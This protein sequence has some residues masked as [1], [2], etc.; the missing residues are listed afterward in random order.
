MGSRICHDLISPLGAIGNGV[1]LIALSGQEQTPEIALIAESVESANARIRFFR[2]AFGAAADEQTIGAQ[3]IGAIFDALDRSGRH[4]I[5]WRAGGGARREVKLAFLVILCIESALP[6]GGTI[7]A[8]RTDDG[9][10]I[11]GR[12]ERAKID[13]ALWSALADLGAPLEVSSAE[14]EFPLARDSA[15]RLGRD[16]QV[17]L[18]ET[19][20]AVTF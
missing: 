12:A 18:A 13:P 7:V 17:A 19:A 1:E 16:L 6:W 15:A 8:E 11:T 10:R 20:V 4:R 14:V 3:E 5:A 2:V 9:W